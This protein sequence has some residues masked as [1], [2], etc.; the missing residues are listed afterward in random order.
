MTTTTLNLSS[1]VLSQPLA[2][3]EPLASYDVRMQSQNVRGLSA[4]SNAD[5]ETVGECVE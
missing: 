2:G 4:F 1:T 5:F 3:L